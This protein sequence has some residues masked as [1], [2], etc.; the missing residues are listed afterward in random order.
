MDP[1]SPFRSVISDPLTSPPPPLAHYNLRT[2]RAMS[3]AT[4]LNLDIHG[5][6]LTYKNAKAGP[7]RERWTTAEIEELCRL[8]D[9]R[10]LFALP[11]NAIP[12]DRRSR[13]LGMTKFNFGFG[14]LLLC[15]MM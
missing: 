4:T 7:D 11:Y 13:K 9:S 3:A 8:I 15:D 6:P 5:Q 1:L 14:L 10:T 12:K 2:R